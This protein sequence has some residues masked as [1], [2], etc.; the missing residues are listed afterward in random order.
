MLCEPFSDISHL[1]LKDLM[2]HAVSMKGGEARAAAG[3][4]SL[5][6]LEGLDGNT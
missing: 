1:F 2:D 5:G 3:E 6:V 4:I